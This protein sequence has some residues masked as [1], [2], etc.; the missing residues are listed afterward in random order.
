LSTLI[1][2]AFSEIVV[3]KA[4][5]LVAMRSASYCSVSRLQPV[6]NMEANQIS[7]SVQLV[8]KMMEKS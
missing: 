7:D 2:T 1:T 4:L 3:Y 6:Y 5:G 8:N